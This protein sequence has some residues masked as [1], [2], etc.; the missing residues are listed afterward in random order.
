MD[1]KIG[2]ETLIFLLIAVV[3]IWRLRSVL[4]R[5]TG[6]ERAR[7]ERAKAEQA[8]QAAD[9]Q[10]RQQV[11][12]NDK[13]VTLPRREPSQEPAVVTGEDRF[14]ESLEE[15]I[16]KFAGANVQLA[17]GLLSIARQDTTFDPDAFLRGGRQ[18]YEM[19]VSAFAAGDRKTLKNMLSP[20][21]YEG[22]VGVISDR[23]E[24][25]ERIEQSFVGID[26][27]DIVEAHT[28][29]SMA[30]ITVKFVSELITTTL[31]KAG[32]AIAGDPKR[33][34]EVTDIWT[35]AREATSRDPNWRLV[36]TEAAH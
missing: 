19:I 36:A 4:G 21:V 14:R 1:G 24:R 31:D 2:L 10:A 30:H 13:V 8:R 15:R 22:F 25:G 5:R 6:D 7:Y 20:E 17:E 12:A 16:R 26:R 23:E 29:G 32:Q 9:A 28:K 33:I 27:A 3:I 35:F 34:I 11:P 18:A